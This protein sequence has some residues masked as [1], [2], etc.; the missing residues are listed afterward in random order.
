[1]KAL[2]PRA[3]SAKIRNKKKLIIINSKEI[4]L[5]REKERERELINKKKLEYSNI[6]NT[7]SLSGIIEND[8]R[9]NIS[10]NIL[11]GSKI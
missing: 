9:I 5:Q 2:F 7:R 6:I 4:E 10:T 1:M 8:E 11:Y 3:L